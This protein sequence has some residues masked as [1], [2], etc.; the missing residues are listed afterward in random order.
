MGHDYDEIAL[1]S[2]FASVQWFPVGD[3]PYLIFFQHN[4]TTLSVLTIPYAGEDLPERLRKK[5]SE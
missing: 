5:W 3:Y 1:A 4:E 2:D